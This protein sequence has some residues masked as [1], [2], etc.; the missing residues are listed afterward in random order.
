MKLYAHNQNHPSVKQISSSITTSNTP[1][2]I[3][4]RSESTNPFRFQKRLK[5]IS[6]KTGAGFDKIPHKWVKYSAK[7]LSTPLSIAINNSLKYGVLLDHTKIASV[8]QKKKKK[9]KNEG[10]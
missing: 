5:G 6:S 4:F 7:I 8:T 10:K 1:K 9:K 2:S 3:S